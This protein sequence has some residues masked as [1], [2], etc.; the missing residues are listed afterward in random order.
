MRLLFV[1][2]VNLWDRWLNRCGG[3]WIGG[4]TIDARFPESR[5]T[6]GTSLRACWI[7]YQ[8]GDV[9]LI[10]ER[11]C[12]GVPVTRSLS[13]PGVLPVGCQTTVAVVCMLN[14]LI[15]AEPA[16]APRSPVRQCVTCER[17]CARLLCLVLLG[18]VYC[19]GVL[20]VD[21]LIYSR[22]RA[23]WARGRVRCVVWCDVTRED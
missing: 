13:Q 22:G 20:T 14:C 8:I 2:C 9:A 16:R 15:G 11:P 3:C 6:R 18:C 23:A 12:D 7:A 21:H 17:M 4:Q 19:S 10:R 5:I 1:L